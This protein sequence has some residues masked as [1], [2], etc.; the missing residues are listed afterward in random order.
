MTW[1]RHVISATLSDGWG[2]QFME[3][4]ASNGMARMIWHST[5]I[6]P[7]I[8]NTLKTVYGKGPHASVQ[9]VKMVL[10][11]DD[12]VLATLENPEVVSQQV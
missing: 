7:H 3:S 1:S 2:R 6:S 4:T 9:K 12:E 10:I 11:N 5:S 8:E